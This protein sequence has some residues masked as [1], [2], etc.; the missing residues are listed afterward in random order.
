MTFDHKAANDYLMTLDNDGLSTLSDLIAR[1]IEYNQHRVLLGMARGTRVRI[2]RTNP[3]YLNGA[4]ATVSRINRTRA[5]V[6]LDLDAGR[7]RAG[8]NITVPA[9][10]LEVV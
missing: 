2:V 6:R 8:V 10:C 9:S 7:F 3:K 5:V 4:L 1:R